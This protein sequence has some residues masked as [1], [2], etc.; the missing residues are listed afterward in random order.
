VIRWLVERNAAV[1]EWLRSRKPW[2]LKLHG[3]AARAFLVAL[4]IL[5]PTHLKRA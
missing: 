1:A 5:I 4:G 2:R 3:A